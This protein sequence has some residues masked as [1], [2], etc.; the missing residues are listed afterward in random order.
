MRV[1]GK[2]ERA[3]S[4]LADSTSDVLAI[5]A[6]RHVHLHR[7]GLLRHGGTACGQD[8][9]HLND[10]DLVF[11]IGH[12]RVGGQSDG[13]EFRDGIA[14]DV[15]GIEVLALAGIAG[16]LDVVVLGHIAGNGVGGRG[17]IYVEHDVVHV[18]AA[19]AHLCHMNALGHHD[20]HVESRIVHHVPFGNSQVSG[21]CSVGCHLQVVPPEFEGLGL[22]LC[23][24]HKGREQQEAY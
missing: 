23:P 4:C 1:E 19:R 22:S 12:R 7:H 10:A 2:D 16:H 15:V 11:A 21:G 6:S 5:H 14:I 13:E 3:D 20:G 9:L 17:A 18:V 8:K 24:R